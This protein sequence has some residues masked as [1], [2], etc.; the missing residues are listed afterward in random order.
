M[1][2]FFLIVLGPAAQ[3]FDVEEMSVIFQRDA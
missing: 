2:T 1:I 3:L